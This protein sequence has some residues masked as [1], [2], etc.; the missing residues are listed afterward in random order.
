MKKYDP[1][2]IKWRDS[3]VLEGV[4]V[5]EIDID[6]AMD[7]IITTV[8]VFVEKSKLWVIVCLGSH[9]GAV[10]RPFFIPRKA[11]VELRKLVVE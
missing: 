4:W 6:S 9:D 7:C 11:I 8:G 10:I 5:D 2:M 3:M 1:V